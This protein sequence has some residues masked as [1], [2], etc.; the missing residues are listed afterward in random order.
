MSRVKQQGGINTKNDEQLG[1]AHCNQGKKARYFVEII[2]TIICTVLFLVGLSVIVL[3]ISGGRIMAVKTASMQ[4]AYPVGSLIVVTDTSPEKIK[5]GKAVVYYLSSGE[6]AVVH[7][8]ISNDKENM[9]LYTKGDS[10]DTPDS[11]PVKYEDVIGKVCFSLP[12]VGYP[13][14]LLGGKTISII[15][16]VIILAYIIINIIRRKYEKSENAAD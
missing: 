5:E 12:I 4:E 3:Y 11:S 16:T 10:N 15:I 1:I 14:I 7:R 6:T 13:F 2:E 8:V 9:L